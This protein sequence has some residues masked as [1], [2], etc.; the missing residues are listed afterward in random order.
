MAKKQSTGPNL[1]GIQKQMLD[2]GKDTRMQSLVQG[3]I[4]L[5]KTK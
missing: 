5:L 4:L 3:A 1:L 2:A